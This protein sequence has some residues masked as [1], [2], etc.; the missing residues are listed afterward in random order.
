MS[1]ILDEIVAYKRTF[2]AERR[3]R[4]PLEEVR[5]RCETTPMPTSLCEALTCGS[6]AA[7]IAEIKKAS[8][9]R[10]MIREDFDPSEIA[11]IYEEGG[12]SALSVLTDE[13][14]FQ[15]CD[16]YLTEAS[17]IVGLPVLR[18]DFTVDPYQI[19]EAR[20]LGAAAVLLIVAILTPEE[21]ASH[22][23]LCREIG[24]DALVEIHTEEEA[25]TAMDSGARIVGINN[26]DLRTFETHLDT[27]LKL[28]EQIPDDLVKVS[29]S[30]IRTREDVVRLRD[31]GIDAVL[32]GESLMR[33][34]DIGRKLRELLGG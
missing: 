19:Y 33:Q 27:T 18:K 32:V 10:G 24:L 6:E 21:I 17:S 2:V 12:A 29:E 23:E 14:F 28:V 15:G 9:S 26:R 4:M 3:Q 16:A 34:P 13:R 7:V 1:S 11:Q 5:A 31:A 22:L 20:S 8:P 30:G 25:R